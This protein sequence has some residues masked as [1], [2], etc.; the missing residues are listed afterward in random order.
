MTIEI[1]G[2]CPPQF[3][4]VERVFASHFERGLELGARFSL[5]IEGEIVVDLMGGWADRAQS[6]PFGPDTLT[7]VFSTTKA[8]AAVMI[9]RL[10]GE[11]RLDYAAPVATVWPQFAASGK[12]GITVEQALSHE[13]GLCG[14][15]A[16]WSPKAW[17]DWDLTCERLAQMAPLWPPGTASGY[18]PVTFG[19]LAGEIFRRVDGRTI[20]AALAEDIA[21]PLGLDLWIGLPDSEHG[22]VADVRRPP[23]M[24]QLGEITEPKRLAFLSPWSTPGGVDAATFRRAEIPSANGHATAAALARFMALIACDGVLDGRRWLPTGAAAAASAQRIAGTDLV[25]PY[26][27]S[28][29]AGL[30]RNQGLGVYG[31][32][33]QSVG[34]SGWGG[35]CAFADPDRRVSGAYVMNRQSADLIADVRSQAL[36]EAAYAAL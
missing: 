5:A 29:G 12:A 13:G 17:L 15:R 27:M 33:A 35:S 3:S 11:G 23:A 20:G 26:E 16:P 14:L 19:Y 28:W 32:G 36:I 30:I 24:P 25:L 18:H 2:V 22:R 8:L 6:R 21:R 4:E 7:M 9:A 34:H 10:V 31:P 1:H